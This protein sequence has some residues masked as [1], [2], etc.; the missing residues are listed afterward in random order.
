MKVA[1]L[2]NA[3]KI[4][5]TPTVLAMMWAYQNWSTEAFV[6]LALH[7]TYTILWLI[8]HAIFPDKSFEER[9]PIAIGFFFVF[10]PLQ[11]YLIAPYL[12]ISR[13]IVHPPY[14]LAAV[15]ALYILGMFLHYASDAQ[16]YFMLRERVRLITDGFFKRSRNPN[17]LGELFIYTSYAILSWHWLS[18][19]V[20]AFWVTNFF[21]RMRRKDKSLARYP[22]FEAYRR[23]SGLL[24]PKLWSPK[25]SDA[26]RN[27]FAHVR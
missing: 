25:T 7:G 23:S 14:I 27:G 19:V 16:K 15:I 13:R 24:L 2:I 9:L 21:L 10:V 1:T 12:L 20:L 17:Y 11:F 18:F 3:H 22:E 4:L 6:Y 8:K 26:E 5:V